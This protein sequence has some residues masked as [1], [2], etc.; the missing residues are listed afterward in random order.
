MQAFDLN[1]VATNNITLEEHEDYKVLST[2]YSGSTGVYENE[3]LN[4]R[5]KIFR[6]KEQKKRRFRQYV[7]SKT[8][9][10]R[11][12]PD[13]HLAFV[14]AVETLGGQE[15]ATPKLVLELMNIRGLS[16]TH[17]KSHL[18]MYRSKKFQDSGRVLS[19][20]G[21]FIN[22]K[23]QIMKMYQR[24]KQ[25]RRDYRNNLLSS[26]LQEPL[27]SNASSASSYAMGRKDTRMVLERNLSNHLIFQ[28][29]PELNICDDIGDILAEYKQLT[30]S[31][32]VE[33]KMKTPHET[34][35]LF[36]QQHF[37]TSTAI[38]ADRSKFESLGLNLHEAYQLQETSKHDVLSQLS[39]SYGCCDHNG[40]KQSSLRSSKDVNTIL[41]L[42]FS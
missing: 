21:G 37:V 1:E 6:G 35:E 17:V 19:S 8:P 26:L 7:R 28:T 27:D 25:L 13:L 30:R 36:L 39:L 15:R 2:T 29:H 9:R 14:N 33:E 18:Q 10:L 16:I 23:A 11:W 20:L 24:V 3:L 4:E 31:R 42:S 41:S 12:T 40:V 38:S 34:S 32:F 22:G 5:S